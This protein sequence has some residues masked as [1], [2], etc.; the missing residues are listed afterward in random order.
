MQEAPDRAEG[1]SVGSRWSGGSPVRA[2]ALQES[3][4]LP[5]FHIRRGVYLSPGV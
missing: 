5:L 4:S 1:P 3:G 2:A